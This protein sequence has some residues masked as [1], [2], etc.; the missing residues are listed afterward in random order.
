M[1]IK[2]L[3]PDLNTYILHTMAN[4]NPVVKNTERK[5]FIEYLQGYPALRLLDTC[6]FYRKVYK[7]VMPVGKSVV[8][9]NNSFS[10][11]EIFSLINEVF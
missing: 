4:T 6:C 8:E 11:N 9:S 10:K 1:K 5:E 7:D 2:D 3:N